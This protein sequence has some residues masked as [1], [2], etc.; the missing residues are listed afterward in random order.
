LLA[1]VEI[2][3]II[4]KFN[5]LLFMCRVNSHK[6]IIIIIIMIIIKKAMKNSSQY[7]SSQRYALC[8]P[9]VKQ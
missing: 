6:A 5:Y 3:I 9:P 7:V 8:P 4:I 1:S 2:I